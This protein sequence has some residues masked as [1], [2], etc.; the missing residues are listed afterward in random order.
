M[1]I[2]PDDIRIFY[3][4]IVLL[5]ISAIVHII[6]AMGIYVEF[7]FDYFWI[8]FIGIFAVFIPALLVQKK[9]PELNKRMAP[10]KLFKIL[11]KGKPKI[12]LFI[13]GFLFIYVILNFFLFQIAAE[14][15]TPE[16][17]DGR[18]VLEHRGEFI[19]YLTETE[20][21]YMRANIVRF[22]TGFCLIFYFFGMSILWPDKK[23]DLKK[24]L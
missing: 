21:Y 11:Y 7:F 24:M 20:F 14:G 23:E 17:T 18:F 9:K 1:P 19:R 22:F 5:I 2:K 10:H 4:S 8:L 6:S 15:G 16:I 13:A 12:M 3:L